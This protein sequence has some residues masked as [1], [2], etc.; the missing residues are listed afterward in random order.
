MVTTIVGGVVTLVTLI[1]AATIVA[2]LVA[3]STPLAPLAMP[4]SYTAYKNNRYTLDVLDNDSDPRSIDMTISA[5]DPPQ[6]GSVKIS[7]NY[8]QLLYTAPSGYSGRVVFNYTITNGKLT[9]S[10]PVTIDVLNIPPET[11]DVSY[12]VSKNKVFEAHLFDYV[13]ESG[14]KIIDLDNDTLII[15]EIAQ[16]SH[17]VAQIAKDVRSVMYTPKHDFRG[18]DR[19][20]Y[21][22]SDGYDTSTSTLQFSIENEPPIA[23]DDIFTTPFQ[24]DM[25][26][27]LDVLANDEDPNGDPIW[28]VD[29]F[30][31][32]RGITVLTIPEEKNG[33]TIK[34]FPS[35]RE[36]LLEEHPDHPDRRG[37]AFQVC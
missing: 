20:T 22:V 37:C 36:S 12:T 5:V 31:I 8:V 32:C 33:T 23:R 18:V 1:S 28:I 15:S 34:V 24:K 27:E 4:D 9:A 17:G 3:S 14:R 2:V 7:E 19:M 29:V 21:T 16:P 35:R 25:A 6:Y 11:V 10:A 13:T 26:H 30:N